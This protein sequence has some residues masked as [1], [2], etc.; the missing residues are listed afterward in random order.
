AFDETGMLVGVGRLHRAAE[1]DQIR[2]M[3]V[4]EACRGKGVGGLILRELEDASQADLIF[5]NARE[6]AVPFYLRHGYRVVGSAPPVVGVPH[7]RM[8][9]R[10]QNAP[11]NPADAHGVY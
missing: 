7:F 8:E 2:Y 10:R 11:G 4:V 3:A 9:K 5:L 6:R 1:G